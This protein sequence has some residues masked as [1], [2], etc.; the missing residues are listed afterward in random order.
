MSAIGTKQ[1]SPTST[2]NACLWHLADVSAFV[3]LS[4][5]SEVKRTLIEAAL[6][7]R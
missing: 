1:K 5:L 6:N 3:D 7:V 4:P 2:T